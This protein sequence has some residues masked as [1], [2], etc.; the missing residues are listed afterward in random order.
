MSSPKGYPSGSK[1]D[2]VNQNFTTIERVRQDQY[3]MSVLAHQYVE[4]I[5]T[6]AVESATTSVIT[7]TAHAALKGDIIRF[8]SGTHSGREVKVDSVAANTITLAED[9]ASAPAALVSFQIL[10]HRYPLVDSNGAA[11]VVGSFTANTN[12]QLDGVDQV[13]TEDT[14][15]PANNR[16]LPVKNFDTS[17][18]PINPATEETLASI[19]GKDFATQTTLAAVLADTTAIKNKDFATQTTLAAL[20]AEDFATQ[21]TLASLEAKD[22]ATETTLAALAAEDFATAANQVTGNTHLNSIDGKVVVVDTDDVTV[23][24]SALPTGAATEA[25]QDTGNTSLSSINSKIT[26]CN[27]EAVTVA[28]SALPTGA[29]TEATLSAASAKLPAT[30]GQKTMANSMA[31]VLSSDQIVSVNPN[32]D[33]IDFID[34]TPVLDTSSTNITASGSNPVQVVATLAAAVK[35][36]R[37]NDTTGEFI[38]VYTGAALSEVLQCIIGPGLD[39]D[40]DVQMSAG[41]RVSLRNMANSAISTGKLCIQFY[42]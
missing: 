5:G 2:R 15:T 36:I 37:V 39:G 11:Q 38:G 29:A 42:G 17:G 31:V 34:T 40:I 7:A 20:A 35:R 41:E 21:A 28:S 18:N 19:D 32:L 9:L 27:T 16:P 1:L 23:T 8:T 10:R 6:D 24:S 13:V 26:A 4:L 3:G 30:L 22:F 12:F 25:K 14:V 33:V